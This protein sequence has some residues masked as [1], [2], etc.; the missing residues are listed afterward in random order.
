MLQ[1]SGQA[2]FVSVA[3]FSYSSSYWKTT[4]LEWTKLLTEQRN[5][6]VSI[7]VHQRRVQSGWNVI[8]CQWRLTAQC[9]LM[10]WI[11]HDQRV[12][13]QLHLIVD[14]LQAEHSTTHH[15][16]CLVSELWRHILVT[17]KHFHLQQQHTDIRYIAAW[18]TT[19]YSIHNITLICQMTA[20]N[21]HQT[22]RRWRRLLAYY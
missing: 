12:L 5:V 13:W 17:K 11:I 14:R 4:A 8:S 7:L 9:F 18:K 19:M 21:K 22:E 15:Q 1:R 3:I 6:E 10:V 2:S 16:T 20:W